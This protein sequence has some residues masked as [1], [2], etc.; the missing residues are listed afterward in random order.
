MANGNFRDRRAASRDERQTN[1][2]DIADMPFLDAAIAER[3]RAAGIGTIDTFLRVDPEALVTRL[4]GAAVSA[5]TVSAWQSQIRLMQTI[6][7]VTARQA[8]LLCGSGYRSAAAISNTDPE[9]FCA[10][11]L[12]FATTD[13]GH[14]VLRDGA[15]PDS[16][17]LRNWITAARAIK[18]A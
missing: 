3:L 6:P 1:S 10:D 15:P 9:K 4:T 8:E 7:G 14:R 12:A 17:V 16:A 5:D 2:P 11:L 18:A 13:E